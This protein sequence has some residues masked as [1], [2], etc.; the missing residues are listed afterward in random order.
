[1]NVFNSALTGCA[2]RSI[3]PKEDFFCNRSRLQ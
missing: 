3:P 2:N 1:M